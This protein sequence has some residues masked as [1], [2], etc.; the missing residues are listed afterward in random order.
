MAHVATRRDL[1]DE[2]TIV[3]FAR[4]VGAVDLLRQL[5]VLTVAD[6]AG[7]APG[8]LTSWKETLFTDLYRASMD[9]LGGVVAGDEGTKRVVSARHD[10]EQ[11]LSGT[12]PE[13][14]LREQ[15]ETFPLGYLQKIAP[16]TA[17][18]HLRMV[19]R[20]DRVGVEV[21]FEPLPGRGLAQV[22]VVT[23]GGLAPGVFA[24]ITGVLAAERLR[25]VDAEIVT[26]TDGDVVDVFRVEDPD[27]GGEPP[28][29]RR[30]EVA[31]RIEEV[32]LGRRSVEE[33]TAA[34]HGV[35]SGPPPHPT[36]QP[37]QVE[38]DVTTSD[39]FTILEIFADDR[40][41][42]LYSLARTLLE[43]D[44]TIATAKI[45][46]SLDQVADVFYVADRAGGKVTD[47]ARLEAIRRRL[48]EVLPSAEPAAR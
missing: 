35:P 27:F 11:K 31:L 48:I 46:T 10:L 39:R 37:T 5:Y 28:Q 30:E 21:S 4:S 25:I 17:A 38:W 26:R 15:L 42:L 8:S 16:E 47:E 23:R 12:F 45:S 43:L 36:G 2:A 40:P 19:Q 1:E 3:S 7:V 20:L 29:H 6:T 14:W 41:G 13:D 24:K 32:V 9:V 18:A 22:V 34:R 44:L 33:L